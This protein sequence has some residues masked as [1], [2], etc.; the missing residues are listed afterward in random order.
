MPVIGLLVQFSLVFLLPIGASADLTGHLQPLGA[1]REPDVPIDEATTPVDP[2]TFWNDYVRTGTPLIFRSA[3]T[4][5]PAFTK[6]TDDYIAS[7]YG[8]VE[9][10]LETKAEV[11][12][13]TPRGDV[14]IGRDT[15]KHFISRYHSDNVY[16]ITELPDSMYHEV[17]VLPCMSC[18]SLRD[19]LQEINLW[20]SGGGT[21]SVLHR[22][23]YHAINCLHN[24][25]KE[26]IM[27]HPDYIDSIYKMEES[28]FEIGGRS[29]INVDKVNM[30]LFPKIANVRYSKFTLHPGD[31]LFLPGGYWHQVRSYGTH[32]LAVAI[33]FRRIQSFREDVGGGDCSNPSYIPLSDYYV[34][35]KFN[36]SGL[37]S[38]GNMDIEA[39]RESF[40][41]GKD[42]EGKA[43]LSDL[44]DSLVEIWE[45]MPEPGR[46]R[47]FERLH[48]VFSILDPD[49]DGYTTEAIVRALTRDQL[50]EMALVLEP[51]E[52]VNTYDYEYALLN[53]DQIERLVE[54]LADKRKLTR[55]N[56]VEAYTRKDGLYG[57]EKFAHRFFDELDKEEKGYVDHLELTG[58]LL[59]LALLPYR[60]HELREAK[61]EQVLSERRDRETEQLLSELD[62]VKHHHGEL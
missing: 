27:I 49:G 15:L 48:E 30:K 55:E 28:E 59:D 62:D 13:H 4:H 6:W 36:G 19:S 7:R 41:R 38:M 54:D 33:L 34:V 5:S 21:S 9:I 61:M 8:D 25:T 23:A 11:D 3:A 24:G 58:G 1:H 42:D 12:W 10:R 22:D 20:I 47:S 56:F 37:M 29:V 51:A 17:D 14:G 44:Y 35:W 31:C 46:T 40:L 18:G 16:A 43:K 57:T 39:M 26:W 60:M 53:A 45:F 52:P 2:K 50:K 32:N